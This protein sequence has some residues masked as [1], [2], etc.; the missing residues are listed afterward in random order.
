MVHRSVDCIVE[1][2]DRINIPSSAPL[3]PA[4]SFVNIKQKTESTSSSNKVVGKT[5]IDE[6]TKGKPKIQNIYKLA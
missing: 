4:P 3:K 1:T 5:P 6:D 2:K